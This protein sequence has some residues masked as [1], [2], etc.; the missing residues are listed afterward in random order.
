MSGKMLALVSLVLPLCHGNR[1][2]VVYLVGVQEYRFN[3]EQKGINQITDKYSTSEKRILE[4][5]L[6]I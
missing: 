6:E 4:R 3:I 1:K 2:N 5:D